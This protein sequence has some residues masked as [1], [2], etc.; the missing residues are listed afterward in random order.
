MKQQNL[1]LTVALAGAVVFGFN[2][3]SGKTAKSAPKEM[4]TIE[5]LLNEMISP[6][7]QALFPAPPYVCLQESSYDRA[8]VSPDAPGWFAN[9]DGFGCVRTDTI[10]GHVERVMFDQKGPGAITRIWITTIDKRGIWRF[11]FD[12]ESKP[13]LE[14]DGYDLMRA[15]IP[16]V[17]E[18]LRQA[19]TSYEPDGKGGNTMF[20]PIPYARGC[21]ITFEDTAGVEPT[22]K[23]YQ[24]NYRRYP[25]ETKVESYSPKAVSRARKS[26]AAADSVM[27]KGPSVPSEAEP[28]AVRT[29]IAGGDSLVLPLPKG[30]NA[31]YE[32][33]FQ[34]NAPDDAEAYAR[35]MRDLVFSATFDGNQTVWVPLGDFSG[36]GMGAPTVDSWFLKS[37]G[38]GHITSRWLMPYRGNC[39][40]RLINNSDSEVE[41]ELKAVTAPLAWNSERSL[42]FHAS[43]R[44]D[45][46]IYLHQRPEDDDK[47]IEW[48]FADLSGRGVYKGDLLSLFNHAPKWYGEGDEKI[49]VDDDLFPSHF[50]T[51]TEDYYN[52]SWAPVVPFQ[53]PFGGAPRADYESSH[54]YNAFFRTRNLDGI[55][56]EKSLKFDIEMIAWEPGTA[57][58]S[59]TVYWYGDAEAHANGTSGTEESSRPLHPAGL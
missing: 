51:G 15:A 11:Y 3:A 16:G 13:R 12:G 41:A 57:D 44:Q 38:R 28:V 10:G 27:L 59:T 29:A 43:W 26:I 19:H 2:H 30:E 36:G 25:E 31:V 47:C 58:Y 6:E 46:D 37:D 54:G 35:I 56:F 17:G 7:E 18:G 45:R 5:S 8:S 33:E 20:L 24:I 9:A 1:I 21:K 23:Y 48:N 53:T 50:G 52:S 32:I 42:Y 55:P 34:V 39:E 14:I 4:V 22:P 40:L 49:W